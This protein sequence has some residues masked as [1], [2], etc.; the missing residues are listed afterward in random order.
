[1]LR[2]VLDSNVLV[3]GLR[4]RRG[5]SFRVLS[6]V[7]AGRFVTVVTVPLVLEYERAVCDTRH[8]WPHRAEDLRAVLDYLCAASERRQVHFLWRPCLPDAND[9]MVLEAAVAGKCTTIVTFNI[10][11]FAGSERFGIR[12]MV[13]GDLL[14]HLG[15]K[16]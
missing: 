1:M 12:A 7:G 3:A 15:E 14:G 16:R 4:S 6:L 10:K 8:A 9:D 11:D 13:P 2:V 5:A